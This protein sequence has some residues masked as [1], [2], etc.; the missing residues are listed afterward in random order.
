VASLYCLVRGM[1]QA[2]W[3]AF[4]GFTIGWAVLCRPT[5]LLIAVPLAVYVFHAHRDQAFRFTVFA[6]PP[7]SFMALYYFWY[8]GS[9]FRIGYDF[10]VLSGRRWAT[11]FF[12][13]LSGILFSPSRGL[14]V[15][16]PVFLF[17]LMGLFLA[18]RYAGHLLLKYV[19]VSVILVTAVYSRWTTWW[20]GWA[21]GPRLL[22][23]I[24]P[25]LTLLLVPAF[26][27]TQQRPILRRSFYALAGISMTI[28]ALGA[29]VN[30]GW[31]PDVGE[32]SQRLWSWSEGELVRS[33]MGMLSKVTG[34][35][36]LQDIPRAGISTERERYSVGDEVSVTLDVQAGRNPIAFDGYLQILRNGQRFR[37]VSSKGL[38]DSPTPF[39]MSSSTAGHHE[40]ILSFWI[41]PDF[42][43]GSYTLQAL[44][45]K[46][47]ASLGSIGG[48]HNRLFESQSVTFTVSR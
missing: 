18:W 35:H 20:G 17:S 23:D 28:H 19:S 13:G 45:F 37:F 16:S 21:F 38:S 1:E 27:R 2:K 31:S 5:D 14:F 24:T 39:V 32:P 29:F 33:V 22:A 43:P 6:L 7:I 47:G 26:H 9:G 41:P 10:G 11:P 25:L 34:K 8:F 42:L 44:L 30:V 4:S 48:R 46:A 36:Y 3:A 12:E 40:F 15:Y